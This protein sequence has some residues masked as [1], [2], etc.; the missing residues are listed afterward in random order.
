MISWQFRPGDIRRSPGNSICPGST[1][2]GVL[3]DPY[4]AVTSGGRILS[5]PWKA[6]KR[7]LA[8]IAVPVPVMN[9]GDAAVVLAYTTT[10]PSLCRIAAAPGF[11]KVLV[12]NR[13]RGGRPGF[14]DTAELLSQWG[15]FW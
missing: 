5:S 6:A 8:P 3:A 7:V 13:G 14:R 11:S 12:L 4:S 9:S 10:L 1:V 2:V 15:A